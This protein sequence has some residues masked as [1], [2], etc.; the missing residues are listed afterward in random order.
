MKRTVGF[1]L[2]LAML[3]AFAACS[4]PAQQPAASG[5]EKVDVSDEVYVWACQ[6]NSLPLFVNNDYIGMDLIAEELGVTVKKIGPQEVDL[7]AFIA[8]IEQEIPNKPDGMMVVG[9]DASLKVPIDKAMDAGIPVITEDADVPDSKRLCFVGTDW[10]QL[11][12]AQAKAAAPYLTN[13]TGKAVL[14]GIPGADNNIQALTGYTNVMKKLAPGITVEQQIY[15][16]ESNAQ[17]VAEVVGNLIK[18]DPSIVAVAGFDST[19]G[20]GIGQAIKEAG[21]QDKVIGTCVDAEPEHLQCVKENSLKAAVGQ[22]RIF[23]TYYG[24]RML[25]DYNHNG[26]KFTTDDAAMGITPIPASISTG[27]IIA[28]PENVQI[29]LDT[30]AAKAK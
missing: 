13:V 27:F 20:P 8:A 2:I 7:P 6:Y 18:S 1:A 21:V 22:K 3:F 16:S 28:T 24:V 11:G 4:A 30:A 12:E 10:T 14:I 17:K 29:M 19:C 9:W 26:I 15:A 5:A 25:Y 23:F